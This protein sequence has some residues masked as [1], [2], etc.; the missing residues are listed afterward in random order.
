M[1]IQIT[2]TAT[3]PND[4]DTV[5]GHAIRFSE[6]ADAMRGLATYEGLPQ[7]PAQQGQTYVVDVTFWKL[8][9]IKGHHIFVETLDFGKRV[10]QSRE[11]NPNVKHWDHNLSVQPDVDGCT[12]TDAV[13]IDAGWQTW[14][15]SRFAAFMYKRRHK[16]RNATTITTQ[17]QRV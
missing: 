17:F 11:H 13:V 6:L 1:P 2:V 14:V 9:K 4:A 12:W 5:F 3:Y 16:L 15:T 8:L 10:I 7:A